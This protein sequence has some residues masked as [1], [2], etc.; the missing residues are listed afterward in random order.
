MATFRTRGEDWASNMASFVDCVQQRWDNQL[1]WID[2]ERVVVAGRGVYLSEPVDCALYSLL[3]RYVTDRIDAVLPDSVHSYRRGRSL[4]SVRSVVRSLKKKYE[5]VARFDIAD[6]FDSART[7]CAVHQLEKMEAPEWLITA[8][9]E[10]HPEH[11]RMG[12]P[13]SNPLSN[14]VLLGLDQFM[15][16]VPQSAYVRYSD[17]FWLFSDDEYVAE[18]T[19]QQVESLLA[20][21]GLQLNTTKTSVM[22]TDEA[23]G[24]IISS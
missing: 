6:F 20:K 21:C 11:L 12:V 5:F 8:V 2:C 17:D 18:D 7:S 10:G 15:E 4:N 3:D 1:F 16:G 19:I 24:G 13:T 22:T 23:I 14:L 9:W